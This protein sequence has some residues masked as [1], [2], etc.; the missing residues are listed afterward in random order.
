[1]NPDDLHAKLNEAL[2]AIKKI[3]P[4][5]P[6]VIIAAFPIPDKEESFVVSGGNMPREAQK[7]MMSMVLG[8]KA[9]GIAPS[10]AH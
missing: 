6:V 8:S 5:T 1:M 10:T 3:L 7:F 9:E 2:D 4:D